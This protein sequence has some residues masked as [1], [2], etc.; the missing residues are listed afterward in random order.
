MNCTTLAETLR[1]SLIA[2]VECRPIDDAAVT[3]TSTFHHD[4]GDLI[5]FVLSADNNHLVLSDAGETAARLFLSGYDVRETESDRRRFL[6][7]LAVVPAVA[8]ELDE[9]SVT[10]D[11]GNVFAAVASL[12]SAISRVESALQMGTV[13]QQE[14]FS[15]QVARILAVNR[16]PFEINHPFQVATAKPIVAQFYVP[17]TKGPR[18]GYALSGKKRVAQP[19]LKARLY[20]IGRLRREQ[21]QML[22]PFFVF[23]DAVTLTEEQFELVGREQVAHFRVPV[24]EDKFLTFLHEAA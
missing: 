15:D 16:I 17:G 23:P 13:R 24:E 9:L 20:D 4:D 19:S 18:V 12:A 2:D 6:R 10:C 14:Y 11:A 5:E 21:D 1:Q 22:F 8:C 7:A 3:F